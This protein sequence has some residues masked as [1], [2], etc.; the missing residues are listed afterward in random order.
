MPY[1]STLGLPQILIDFQSAASTAMIRS[2]RGVGAMILNEPSVVNEDGVVY[3]NIKDSTGI[4]ATGISAKN[5]DLIKKGLEGA[6]AQLHIFLIPNATYEQEQ[7]TVTETTVE[8]TTTVESEVTVTIPATEEGGEP[9]TETQLQPVEVETTVTV[10]GTT[11]TTVTVEATVKQADALKKLTGMKFNW[12]CHPTGTTQDQQ[13]LAVWVKTQRATKHKSFKAVVAHYAADDYGVVNFTTEKI[14]VVNPDY[15]DALAEVGGDSELVDSSIPQ[16][17]TY[18]ATEYTA[19]IMGLLAGI[20][21]DRSSTYYQLPE[22]VDCELYDDID[23]HIDSGELCLFDEHDGNGVKIARGCNSL[24]TFTAKIG[25]SFRY[26]KIIEAID[27]IS[28]DIS[29]TFRN[30][31]VGKVINSYE[32]KCLFIEAIMVYLNQLR[33]TVLD[34]SDTAQNYV[35]ID[36]DAHR[37]WASVN[38]V[39]LDEYSDQQLLELNTGSWVFLRG[40]ITPVNSLEDLELHFTL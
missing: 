25:E 3:Y 21:L 37:D 36:T 34:N 17:I 12:I 9:T 29:T 39:K 23:A 5:I 4:P 14:R 35:E 16:Y 20:P 30:D 18:S 19:R 1:T 11:L 38:S 7:E 10:T 33:G 2:S 8:T 40:R 28:D 26:I 15:T 6:P 22:I 24:I 13:D 32:N 27:L 31:Y